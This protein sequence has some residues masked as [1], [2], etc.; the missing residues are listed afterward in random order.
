MEC[1]VQVL[2]NA[3]GQRQELAADL[4]QLDFARA[5]IDDLHP[6][7]LLQLLDQAAQCRLRDVQLLRSTCEACR[8]GNGHKGAELAQS[9]I[10]L[11]V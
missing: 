2:Q 10:H 7:D 9:Y 8:L 1:F 11:I 4:R 6:E 3:G 5:A